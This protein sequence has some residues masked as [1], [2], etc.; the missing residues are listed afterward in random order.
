MSGLNKLSC[1]TGV[2]GN[3]G[4]NSCAFDPDHIIG[5]LIAPLNF[6]VTYSDSTGKY[7]WEGVEFDTAIEALQASTLAVTA[8]RTYPIWKFESL[9]DNSET[10]TVSTSGYG[11]KSYVKEGKYDWSFQLAQSF[12]SVC[13]LKRLR[14]FNE[15]KNYGVLFFD[16]KDRIFGT[17]TADSDG[18]APVTMEF[19]HAEP[20]KIADGSN[21]TKYMLRFALAN[22]AELNDYPAFYELESTATG[23]KGI[24]DLTLSSASAAT[25][26]HV[27]VK[28]TTTQGGIDVYDSFADTL[29]DA[30][31]WVLTKAGVAQVISAVTKSESLRGWDVAS[32]A[33]GACVLALAPADELAALGVGGGS[34]YGYEGS[35]TYA[36]TIPS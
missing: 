30:D 15:L 26:G 22:P 32:A 33:T 6:K 9:T 27:F 14:Q 3:T 12:G 23:I 18:I 31:A 4:I 24:V 36:V 17:L 35:N 10:G 7:T 20:F 21:V 8:K 34:E 11:D 19:F 5:A 29:A 2:G 1:T 13:F 16:A 28:L 25:A